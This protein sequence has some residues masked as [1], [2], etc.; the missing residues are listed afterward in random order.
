MRGL[1]TAVMLELV[2]VTAVVAQDDA[3]SGE[4]VYRQNCA[5]CHDGAVG[6]LVSADA[7]RE[8]SADQIYATLT[9]GMMKRQ[10]RALSI[11]DRQAVAEYLSGVAL[12]DP[13]LQQIPQFAYCENRASAGNPLSGAQWNGWGA[14][15]SNTRMQTAESAGLTRDDFPE[16]RLKWSFGF[17]GV[18]RAG[19]QPTVVGGQVLVGTEVG[20]VYSID[21][22]SGCITWVYE[23]ESGVRT[24]MSVGQG[25]DGSF[26][27]YFGD[28]SANVYAVDFAT[29]AL[30][31]KVRVDEHPDAR[32]TGAPALHDGR[33][34]VPVSSLEE[35]TAVMASYECCTFRGSVVALNART[36]QQIWK[37]YA[38]PYEPQV[39]GRN[40]A[41]AD[42]LGPSG[43]G[44][45]SAPTLD[46]ERNRLYVATGD[47]YSNPAAA[48]S[49]ALMAITMDTGRV[50]WVSQT[51]PGDA[52]N[53]ACQATVEAATANCPEDAGPD[54]DYGS[55]II[56]TGVLSNG[57]PVLLSGQKSGVM[58]GLDANTGE[59]L[60]ETRVADG[61]LLGGIE[62]GFAA[63]SEKTYVTASDA[64]EKPSG[65]AG[66]LTALDIATGEVAWFAPPVQGTCEGRP[67]CHTGQPSAVS[68]I[69]GVVLAGSLDGHLRAHDTE[70]G[71]ILW[72]IDTV[73]QFE[74]VNGVPGNG[75]ALNGPGVTVVDGSLFIV[76][77]YSGR[78]MSGNVLLAYTVDGR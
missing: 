16:L 48:E 66:G 18:A 12:S 39:T 68:L 50:L 19:S 9:S 14:G 53:I 76:S 11:Q 51:L 41:G 26:F 77:G 1:L 8:R 34:Y 60:W 4:T 69:P 70:T 7:I 31:W 20:L 71:Q 44:I 5:R 30:R 78:W 74:T 10:G 57:R 3:R 24:T 28:F 15:L 17:P 38:I 75:G 27:A 58:Y 35:G 2:L 37:R 64:Y 47:S 23:A 6:R 25:P 55:S 49:D 61:G 62:W 21:A 32:I 36:G 29:G 45:W 46:P 54:H 42:R 63:D 52:W 43:A 13:P 33:L 67:G 56:I 40:A 65:E 73:G 22:E 72:D 59:I